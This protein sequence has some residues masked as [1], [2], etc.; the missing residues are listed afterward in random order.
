MAITIGEHPRGETRREAE[1]WLKTVLTPLWRA[2]QSTQECL[3]TWDV[4]ASASVFG[5]IRQSGEAIPPNYE[6]NYDQF[7]KRHPPVAGLVLKYDSDIDA[8]REAFKKSEAPYALASERTQ[9]QNSARELIQ[10]LRLVIL[11]IADRHGLPPVEPSE[12]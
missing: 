12:Q 8:L 9:L 2:V 5:F 3:E 4:A 10:E 11:A 1:A 6:L 7:A